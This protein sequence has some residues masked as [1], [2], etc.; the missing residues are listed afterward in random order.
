MD[1]PTALEDLDRRAL[2]GRALAY[3]Q[4][5]ERWLEH[6]NDGDV[7][8][9]ADPL[10]IVRRFAPFIALQIR[11]RN[12]EVALLAIERSRTAWLELVKQKA[13]RLPLAASFVSDLVW[14]K[15]EV[16]RVFP[17]AA[18]A[19]DGVC[20]VVGVDRVPTM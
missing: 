13:I 20:S 10:T 16:V 15:H 9:A 12:A 6:R 7:V 5:C 14:L 8:D 19:S 17:H 11:D 18:E 1:D 4:R 3:A 2:A